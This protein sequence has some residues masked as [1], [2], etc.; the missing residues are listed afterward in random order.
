MK[1]ARREDLP[2]EKRVDIVNSYFRTKGI[3]GAV[4]RLAEQHNISRSDRYQLT[5][6]AL[7]C[8]TE[9]FSVDSQKVNP[10]CFPTEQ[11]IVLLRLEGKC[12]VGSISEILKILNHPNSS[13]GMI[14]WV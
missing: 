6:M 7:W 12:S 5:G 11:L 1:F 14:S 8:L 4:T 10:H 2:P 13:T 9:L 3:Y